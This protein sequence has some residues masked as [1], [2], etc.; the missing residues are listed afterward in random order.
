MMTF[1]DDIQIPD[2]HPGQV[3]VWKFRI[4][5]N[6]QVFSQA[7]SLLSPDEMNRALRYKFDLHR[8]RFA[9]CR[10]VVRVL[11]AN[12]LNTRPQVINFVYGKSGKP[13]LEDNLI[14]FNLSHTHD[15]AV[16]AIS[17]D[18]QMGVDLEQVVSLPDQ[19]SIA[20]QF[21]AKPEIE[22]LFQLPE[23]AQQFAFFRCWTRKE[24]YIKAVGEGLGL[25][26]DQFTVPVGEDVLQS[27][28]HISNHHAEKQPWWLE[29]IP[30]PAGYVGAIVTDRPDTELLFSQ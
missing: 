7:K 17:R 20:N 10:A 13:V 27:P 5:A 12:Y 18:T 2:L 29:D 23:K 30:A 15:Q 22:Q 19:R 8:W 26:L 16:L 9:Y 28:F 24:A 11:L 3:L 4:H 1:L 25:G 14:F 6:A 21:F